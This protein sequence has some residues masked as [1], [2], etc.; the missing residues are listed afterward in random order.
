MKYTN[1]EGLIE[2][3]VFEV[4]FHHTLKTFIFFDN[5]VE[6]SCILCTSGEASLW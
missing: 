6:L 2:I 3:I 1:T 5:V 4:D